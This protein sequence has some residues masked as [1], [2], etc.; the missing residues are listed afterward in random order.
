MKLTNIKDFLSERSQKGKDYR[1]VN[2]TNDFGNQNSHISTEK[3]TSDLRLE[4]DQIWKFIEHY[5]NSHYFLYFIHSITSY[6]MFGITSE[7]Y[8]NEFKI[9]IS[10]IKIRYFK[11]LFDDI[12]S[13]F[14]R[15]LNILER[16]I[17]SEIWI[18]I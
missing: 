15:K 7:A 11:I 6:S 14:S 10:G 18:F 8:A 3:S 4:N 5:S 12:L 2:F 1:Q 13:V 16:L 9:E 17:F